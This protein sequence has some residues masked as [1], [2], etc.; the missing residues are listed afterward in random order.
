MKTIRKENLG[1]EPLPYNLAYMSVGQQ[2]G[3][4]RADL[5]GLTYMYT[6]P[7]Y[8]GRKLNSPVLLL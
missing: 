1:V 4:M 5:T 7:S 2:T 6:Q 8:K 3:F